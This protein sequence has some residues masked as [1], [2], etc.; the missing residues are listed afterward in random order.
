M[1]QTLTK[2]ERAVRRMVDAGDVAAALDSNKPVVFTTDGTLVPV[3][4]AKSAGLPSDQA[5]KLSPAVLA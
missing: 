4:A 5:V 2:V 1:G 3:A